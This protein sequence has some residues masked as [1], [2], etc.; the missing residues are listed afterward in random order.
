MKPEETPVS[1]KEPT[2]IEDIQ[3]YLKDLTIYDGSHIYSP[4]LS[5]IQVPVYSDNALEQVRLTNHLIYCLK[6]DI[7][8]PTSALENK[9]RSVYL[10]DFFVDNNGN[11]D[12]VVERSN[13]L[14]NSAYKLITLFIEK[15]QTQQTDSNTFHN[16]L[17]LGPITQALIGYYQILRTF[18]QNEP[19]TRTRYPNR[20][21]G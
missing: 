16:R 8:I 9:L 11:Y 3:R 10:R 13:E 15:E 5:A 19:S 7:H 4:T 18:Y 1:Y 17:V 12:D 6:N 14:S 20:D 2:P 21:S